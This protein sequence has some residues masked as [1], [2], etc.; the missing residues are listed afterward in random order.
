MS[1]PLLGWKR[2]GGKVGGPTKRNSFNWGKKQQIISSISKGL[3]DD[4]EKKPASSKSPPEKVNSVFQ[5]YR[6]GTKEGFHEEI[7][8]ISRTSSKIMGATS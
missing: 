5:Y 2:G 6:M 8:G 1:R 7:W 3:Q 4:R